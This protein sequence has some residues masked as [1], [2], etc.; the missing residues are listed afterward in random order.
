MSQSVT[1]S[2]PT[3]AND[4]C[5]FASAVLTRRMPSNCSMMYESTEVVFDDIVVG[6]PVCFK[7]AGT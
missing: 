1:G 2:L 3:L 6:T 5:Y 7:N 4:G